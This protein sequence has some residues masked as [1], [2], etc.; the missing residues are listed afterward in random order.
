MHIFIIEG[1]HYSMNRNDPWIVRLQVEL[2]IFLF[3]AFYKFSAMSIYYFCNEFLKVIIEEKNSLD[4]EVAWKVICKKLH[5]PQ[6][7]WQKA[8]HLFLLSTQIKISI[9]SGKVTFFHL[10]CDLSGG[11]LVW[12]VQHNK[13]SPTLICLQGWGTGFLRVAWWQPQYNT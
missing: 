4:E 9:A 6:S 13:C 3:F 1:S 11:R 5:S 12:S 7:I 2:L 10:T 8:P